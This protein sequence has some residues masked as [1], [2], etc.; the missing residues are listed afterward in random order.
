[1]IWM[2]DVSLVHIQVSV[3]QVFSQIS[4]S[5]L[6]LYVVPMFVFGMDITENCSPLWDF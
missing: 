4:L 1:M 5:S 6:L 2:D 3:L